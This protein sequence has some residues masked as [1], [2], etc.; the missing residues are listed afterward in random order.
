MKFEII[1]GLWSFIDL[2]IACHFS[3]MNNQRVSD[4]LK[5]D[6]SRVFYQIG[7]KYLIRKIES[8]AQDIDIRPTKTLYVTQDLTIVFTR[9]L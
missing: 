9:D 5:Y 6:K 7:C 8:S 2:D 3:Y 4:I 1:C